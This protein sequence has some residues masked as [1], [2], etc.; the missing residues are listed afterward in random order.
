M[1]PVLWRIMEIKTF[2]GGFDNNLCHLVWCRQTRVAAIVDPSV[3]A[4]P[5]WDTILEH[6]LI[7]EKIILTHT[8]ADHYAYLDE[9]K[10]YRLLL[11]VYGYQHPVN[12][13]GEGEY[14]GVMHNDVI[15]V[16]RH[17]LTVLH[18]PGHFPDCICLWDN[19][20]DVLFTGDT[21]FVGRTGRTK[22]PLSN[23]SQLYDSVYK[24]IL[25]LSPDTRIYPGHHYGHSFSITLRENIRLSRFF[26]CRSKAEFIRVMAEFERKRGEK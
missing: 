9:F 17:L 21:V 10:N 6:G 23:I 5:V 16:G 12:M 2:Q 1:Y 18:T 24:T 25:P 14:V 13:P 20:N 26:Q 4:L 19:E 8:H 11:K 22:D 3:E 15:S 7:L